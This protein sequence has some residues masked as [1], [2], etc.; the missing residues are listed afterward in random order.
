MK[1]CIDPGH[2]GKTS[3]AV[4]KYSKEKDINLKLAL[5]MSEKL[6]KCGIDVLLTRKD[7][8]YVSLAERCK[9]AN[10]AKSN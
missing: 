9:M 2:G 3:G 4:G 5:K 7:D 10:R 6:T 1:V 8:T